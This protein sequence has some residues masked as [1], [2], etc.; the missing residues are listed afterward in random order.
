LNKIS[1]FRQDRDLTQSALAEIIGVSLMTI[2]RWERE[3]TELPSSAIIKLADFF[4]VSFEEVLGR[5]APVPKIVYKE[6]DNVYQYMI[7]KLES[8][9]NSEL[10]RIQGAVESLL[11]NRNNPTAGS[12]LSI[13]EERVA[14]KKGS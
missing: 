13:R 2:S 9:S 1:D 7:T 10:L 12:T 11:Y 5:K 6:I 14:S 4:G 8:L 3:Q